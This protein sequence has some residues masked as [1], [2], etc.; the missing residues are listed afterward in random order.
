MSRFVC[1]CGDLRRAGCGEGDESPIGTAR[2]PLLC[3]D[4]AFQNIHL[5]EGQHAFQV[6][7]GDLGCI[8]PLLEKSKEL[9]INTEIVAGGRV[10]RFDL[11]ETIRPEGYVQV[12]LHTMSVLLFNGNTHRSTQNTTAD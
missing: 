7:V 1:P 11:Q 12:H 2:S 10:E 9:L 3:C 5:D 6:H 8:P 4:V